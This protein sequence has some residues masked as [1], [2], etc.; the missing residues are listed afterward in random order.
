MVL[1]N[2]NYP[3]FFAHPEADERN[4]CGTA[5]TASKYDVGIP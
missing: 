2:G 5:K 1:S 3:F 4:V